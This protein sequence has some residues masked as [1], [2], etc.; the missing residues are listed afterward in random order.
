[1]TFSYLRKSV[2]VK[3]NANRAY[4]SAFGKL[5]DTHRKTWVYSYSDT[6]SDY[7]RHKKTGRYIKCLKESEQ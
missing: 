1:M 4:S 7:F 5:A 2:R 6:H 3:S